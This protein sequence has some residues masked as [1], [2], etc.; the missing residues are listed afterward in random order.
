MSTPD[1]N[2]C[3][4][5]TLSQRECPSCGARTKRSTI[6]IPDAPGGVGNAGPGPHHGW[7]C[8]ACHALWDGGRAYGY[9]CEAHGGHP[10]V[11]PPAAKSIAPGT[12]LGGDRRRRR[13]KIGR[14]DPCPCG[15]GKKHKKCCIDKMDVE[16][17][18]QFEVKCPCGKKAFVGMEPETQEPVLLHQMPYCET[19]EKLP[20]EEYLRWIRGNL[21]GR[22]DS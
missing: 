5:I 3:A 16:V 18:A 15:S 4:E 1:C 8:E 12:P 19:F 11:R 22:F 14:N 20:A 7:H 10:L 9:A 17:Q 2:E 21:E 13:V 6:T